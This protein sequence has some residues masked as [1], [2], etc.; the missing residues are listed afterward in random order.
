[1]YS[2]EKESNQSYFYE[3]E[4]WRVQRTIIIFKSLMATIDDSNK[5]DASGEG[6]GKILKNC[7][8]GGQ[9][10]KG[11]LLPKDFSGRQLGS[12][13]KI[14]KNMPIHWTSNYSLGNIF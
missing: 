10:D 4:P 11:I 13:I 12:C 5:R 7:Q 14:L 3:A 1:M 2:D 6:R 9:T 8:S